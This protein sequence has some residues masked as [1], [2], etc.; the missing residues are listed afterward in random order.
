MFRRSRSDFLGV[1]VGEDEE[2]GKDRSAFSNKD[3]DCS[4]TGVEVRDGPGEG[5]WNLFVSSKLK[6]HSTYKDQVSKTV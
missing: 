6:V 4:F 5:V 3:E 1:R 2:E